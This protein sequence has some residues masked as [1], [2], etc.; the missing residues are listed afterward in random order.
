MPKSLRLNFLTTIWRVGIGGLCLS[1]A[2]LSSLKTSVYL[3]GKYSQRRHIRS[4][5]GE[6]VPIIS[7]RTQQRPILH[8]IAQ[9]AVLEAY[10]DAIYARFMR[11]KSDAVRHGLSTTLKAHVAQVTQ[12]S[13][14]DL[15]ERC[16]AQGLFGYNQIIES[17]LGTR[18]INIAEG[19]ILVLAIRKFTLV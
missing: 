5:T 19:D 15:T 1:M 17:Q 3:V 6:V 10:G 4:S 8:T 7:F 12:K 2:N 18:G 14:F 11:E 13:L 9:I 16:G